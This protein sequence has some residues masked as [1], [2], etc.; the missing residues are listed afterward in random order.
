MSAGQ[1]EYDWFFFD[2]AGNM[3]TGW[4]LDGDGN[5]YYLNNESNG[6]RGSMMTGWCWIPDANGVRKC[7]YLNPNSDGTRGK[8]LTNASIGGFTVNANGEW[9]VDGVVQT[10]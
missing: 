6:T 5:Y 8:L 1:Q 9:V 4:M 10:R 2:E 7:Y 3:K